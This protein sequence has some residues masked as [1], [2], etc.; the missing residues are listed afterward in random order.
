MDDR[1]LLEN[2]AKAAGMHEHRYCE[3][4]KAMAQYTPQNGYFGPSW[5][6]LTNSGNALDMA[7]DLRFTVKI[8]DH[9][10]EVFD[11]VSGECLASVEMFHPSDDDARKA[12]RLAITIAAA[13]LASRTEKE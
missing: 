7:V 12:A 2:A 6:P 5:N 1:E 9:E 8:A 13:A 10:C 4:W 11:E 3:A